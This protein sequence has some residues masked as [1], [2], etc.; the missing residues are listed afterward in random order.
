MFLARTATSVSSH[1]CGKL[2]YML[3]PTWT[4]PTGRSPHGHAPGWEAGVD[5]LAKIISQHAMQEVSVTRFSL[6]NIWVHGFCGLVLFYFSSVDHLNLY[7][8][9]C[10]VVN[11]WNFSFWLTLKWPTVYFQHLALCFVL[12]FLRLLEKD[13]LFDLLLWS[14]AR[15]LETITVCNA[16]VGFHI[17]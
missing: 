17:Y 13:V 15:S 12:F 3:P 5:V 7:L 2:V 1:Q 10:W 4:Y 6:F 9:M 11:G 14:T 8:T 16:L